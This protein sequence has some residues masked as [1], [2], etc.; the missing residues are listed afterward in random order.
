MADAARM[1]PGV[2]GD[3]VPSVTCTRFYKAPPPLPH[4]PARPL[5]HTPPQQS[6][7]EGNRCLSNPI[8]ALARSLLWTSGPVSDPAATQP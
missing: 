6:P 4:G 2:D 3:R 8:A 5:R 1:V 7:S